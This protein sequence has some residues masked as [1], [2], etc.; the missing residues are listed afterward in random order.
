MKFKIRIREERLEEEIVWKKMKVKMI[1]KYK[2]IIKHRKEKDKINSKRE[3]KL[4]KIINQILVHYSAHLINHYNLLNNIKIIFFLQNLS[5]IHNLGDSQ[6]D[7]MVIH[8]NQCP[9]LRD[10]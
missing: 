6:I 9:I 7:N 2:G 5:S 3:L 1:I 4:Y 10:Q 8:Y